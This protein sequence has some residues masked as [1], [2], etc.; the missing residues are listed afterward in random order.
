MKYNASVAILVLT[1]SRTNFCLVRHGLTS[2]YAICLVV[3][4][5]LPV[6]FISSLN[7]SLTNIHERSVFEVGNVYERLFLSFALLFNAS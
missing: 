4:K 2:L 7:R 5:P 6:V 3:D 1:K